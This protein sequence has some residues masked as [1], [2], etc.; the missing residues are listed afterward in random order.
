MKSLKELRTIDLKLSSIDLY[1]SKVKELERRKLDMDVWLPSR[2]TNLQRGNVWTIA[3]KRELIISVFLERYIPP[4]CIMSLIDGDGVHEQDIIQVIDGKQ[5][6]NT[7]IEFINDKFFI[8]LEDMSYLC[9]ALPDDYKK[10]VLNYEIKGQT[11]YEFHEKKITDDDKV[12][13]F[14][15]INFFGTPQDIE[16]LKTIQ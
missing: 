12:N 5:R 10:A 1:F 4:V 2:N 9:S 6:L 7:F 3:Q 16:H 14:K 8:E 13:W 15:R 11:C